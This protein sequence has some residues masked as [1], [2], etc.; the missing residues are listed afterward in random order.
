MTLFTDNPFEKM[1]IQKPDYGKREKSPPEI[2]SPRCAGCPYKG[3]SPCGMTGMP[4]VCGES[5]RRA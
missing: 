1:M 2:S 3:Q 5:P 4:S